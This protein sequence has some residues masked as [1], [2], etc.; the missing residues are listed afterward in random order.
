MK[1]YFRKVQSNT[2]Q[3]RSSALEQMPIYLIFIVL[4]EHCP[5]READAS[6]GKTSPGANWFPKIKNDRI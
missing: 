5:H 4:E 1:E 2:A 3:G 6:T